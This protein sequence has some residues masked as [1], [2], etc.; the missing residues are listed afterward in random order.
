MQV[1]LLDLTFIFRKIHQSFIG[2]PLLTIGSKKDYTF[3]FGVLRELLRIRQ[4]LGINNGTLALGREA[5]SVTSE[6]NI[7]DVVTLLREIEFP[8]IC[9]S[10]KSILD[11]CFLLA[12]QI[13][14]IFT[15]DARIL[16]LTKDNLGIIFWGGSAISTYSS[17]KDIK[18]GIG[19]NPEY[20]PTYLTLT[21]SSSSTLTKRQAIR[22]IELHGSLES[23]YENA[24]KIT[25]KIRE[26]LFLNEKSIFKFYRYN[27]VERNKSPES[28][29]IGNRRIDL[30]NPRTIALLKEYGFFSL[31]RLLKKPTNISIEKVNKES[32]NYKPVIDSG[33][34]KEF[35]SVI[36]SSRLCAID[37]ESDDKDLYRATLLGVA[38]SIKK[39][40]A[41]FVPLVENDLKDITLRDVSK[42]L[43]KIFRSQINFIGHNIKYDYLLLRRHNFKMKN[44]HFDTM[45]AAYDCYDDWEFFNLSFIA[46]KLL[47]RKIKSYKEIVDKNRTFLDMPFS[48][49]VKHGCED[50]DITLCIYP[51]LYNELEKRSLLKDYRQSTIPL[52]KK[53]ADLEFNGIH[54]KKYRLEKIRSTLLDK[55]LSTKEKIYKIVGRTF[56]IDS[57]KELAIILKQHLSLITFKGQQ[58]VTLPLLE[59]LAINDQSLKLIVSY[60]RFSKQIKGIE[61]ILKSIKGK[62][63][64]PVFN[65]IKPPHGRLST[66]NPSLFDVEGIDDLKT[67]FS[68]AI[69]DYFMDSKK[70]LDYIQDITEDDKLKIDRKFNENEF[71]KAHRLT[72]QFNTDELLLSIIIGDSNF[73]LSRRFMI[74][75]FTAATIRHDV[76]TR[77]SLLFRWMDNFKMQTDRR[78]YAIKDGKR[79]YFNGLRSSNVEKRKKAINNSVRWL[80]QY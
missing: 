74:D 44:I 55:I 4:K 36:L 48:E 22:L 61:A 43:R 72:S 63:C 76:E 9:N 30:D 52:I 77:Y 37:T 39:G 31:I 40:E 33:G 70:S 8:F 59:Q 38:F 78:G 35:E 71:L 56:D 46:Q 5:F 45:L 47:N 80:I 64:Y 21:K 12:P 25:P 16:Q 53:L 54:V 10:N 13:S 60:K 14:Y 79:K 58:K 17:P 34:L 20:M 51:F 24:Q 15:S 68:E 42:T 67:C 73:K 49:I 27:R 1:V 66:R 41:Y 18:T 62:K 19:I 3:L 2:A 7:E 65:Q 69:S 23:I 28:Y 32:N 26:W 50:A 75:R 29:K 57:Q 11:I 6:D